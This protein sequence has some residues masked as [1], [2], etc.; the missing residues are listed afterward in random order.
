[1]TVAPR[2]SALVVGDK[3]VPFRPGLALTAEIVTERRS[4]LAFFL[5]PVRKLK[6]ATES[7]RR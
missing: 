7:L 1:V 3:T 2:R 4:V 5:T 6:G